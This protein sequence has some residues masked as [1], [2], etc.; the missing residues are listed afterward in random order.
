[1]TERDRE[2]RGSDP[3]GLLVPEDLDDPEGGG[4]PT[5][6]EGRLVRMEGMLARLCEVAARSSDVQRTENDRRSEF[7]ELRGKL[8]GLSCDVAMISASTADMAK[9]HDLE[10]VARTQREEFAWFRECHA[11][12]RGAVT[13]GVQGAAPRS[14]VIALCMLWAIAAFAAFGTGAVAVGLVSVS[15][16]WNGGGL[17]ERVSQR[18]PP[19]PLSDVI[20]L[21]AGDVVVPAERA[22][23]LPERMP[24]SVGE[25][26]DLPSVSDRN[27]VD[28][29]GPPSLRSERVEDRREAESDSSPAGNSAASGSG[30]R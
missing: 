8:T 30:G 24:P 23:S 20:P 18:R 22:E 9:R 12:L 5:G 25:R 2:T 6:V 15:V 28:L 17:A 1:M 7:S 26:R 14:G 4:R 19:P 21:D 27:H 11:W 3:G 13:A 29:M 10:D 16:S